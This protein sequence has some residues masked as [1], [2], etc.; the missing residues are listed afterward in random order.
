MKLVKYRCPECL[1]SV[2]VTPVNRYRK[3][4]PAPADPC[5]M[6]HEPVPVRTLKAGP[7][8]NNDEPVKGR[9][10]DQCPMCDR[11]PKLDADGAFKEHAEAKGSDA[12]CSFSG[13]LP[14]GKKPG[15]IPGA[16][17]YAKKL[18]AVA[19]VTAPCPELG[20]ERTP[21]IQD[22][23]TLNVHMKKDW[24]QEVC[25]MSRQK[26]DAQLT[27]MQTEGS[28]NSA[29]NVPATE[30]LF[31]TEVFLNGELSPQQPRRVET[32]ALPAAESSMVSSAPR[33]DGAVS[34][35]TSSVP[36]P[37][38]ATGTNQGAQFEALK[39]AD[40]PAEFQALADA[41]P[42]SA[43]TPDST[44]TAVAPQ[45]SA[46]APDTGIA[47]THTGMDSPTHAP[48]DGATGLATDWNPPPEITHQL[49]FGET[50]PI[51][52]DRLEFISCSCGLPAGAGHVVHESCVLTF[53]EKHR[54]C[55]SCG[56]LLRSQHHCDGKPKGYAD[57]FVAAG[58]EPN[59]FVAAGEIPAPLQPLP[60]DQMSAQLVASMK[61]IFYAYSNRLDRSIQETL[62]PSEIGTP[63]DRRLAMSIMQVP[64]VNPGG[65]NW[66]S[67]V[68]TCVHTGLADMLT[69]AD[70]NQGRWAVE[71]RLEYPNVLVP[72]GT[73]DAYDRVAMMVDDHK[74]MGRWSLDKLRLEG[75]KPLYLVQLMVY[76]YGLKLKG[77]KVKYVALVAWPRE[78]ATLKDLTAVVLP[79]D[80]TVADQA[81]ARV[82]HIAEVIQQRR[83]DTNLTP[84]RIARGFEVQDDCTYCPFFAKGDSEME[85]GCN[86][87]R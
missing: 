70:A 17:E 34:A 53:R 20:C 81:F 65:D 80:A 18:E 37:A 13:R 15:T 24:G 2:A 5:R 87:K 16:T 76:A 83:Q 57:M 19:I 43:R 27:P 79:Y 22:D 28:A 72:R 40:P 48:V 29:N 55:E 45:V 78:Q 56:D 42:K 62:G 32:L 4:P 6:T 33:G 21:T 85:R 38:P 77:E 47:T 52:L 82:D 41:F 49:K 7:D 9:D 63:C 8:N 39:R 61:E 44:V 86:G 60:M 30:P 84:F 31:P 10:Y 71:T 50:P 67:F 54:V 3:H 75:I 59:P 66:A 74:L 46:V 35:P 12:I 73:A 25:P 58:G 1:N 68:G 51:P 14:D 11:M 23:G 69:W 36:V 64:P 26:P